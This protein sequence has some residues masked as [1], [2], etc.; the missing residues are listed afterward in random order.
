M[1]I[2]T[3]EIRVQ[4]NEKCK[5]EIVISTGL[6]RFQIH[7]EVEKLKAITGKGKSL[8]IEIKQHSEKRS[9]DANAMLWVMCHQIAESLKSTKEEIYRRAIKE[10][11]V[12]EIV[13]IANE[14]VERWIEC[15]NGKGIGW[16]AEEIAGSKTPGYTRVISYYGSSVYNTKEMSV[17]LDHIITDAREAGI[18]VMT[19]SEK[20]LLLQAWEKK[21]KAS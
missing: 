15:W 13:P 16:H 1:K 5:A 3:H 17:L 20:H 8:D 6:N 18:D 4:Y 19:E 9:N 12:F 7:P 21:Q 14:A 10:V 11:G 2:K